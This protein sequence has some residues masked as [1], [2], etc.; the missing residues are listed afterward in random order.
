MKHIE[1]IMMSIYYQV[2]FKFYIIK[3][4][5]IYVIYNN[6]TH[7]ATVKERMRILNQTS[8]NVAKLSAI[9]K[10][11]DMGII[12]EPIDTS[13]TYEKLQEKLYTDQDLRKKVYNLFNNDTQT[14]EDFLE[15]FEQNNKSYDN[16]NLV[17]NQ[18][19]QQF[20]GF[21]ASPVVVFDVMNKLSKNVKQTG[22]P[23]SA[24]LYD[25][26]RE[27]QVFLEEQFKQNN[28][29]KEQGDDMVDKLNAINELLIRNVNL[30]KDETSSFIN[31]SE[32]LVETFE[33]VKI[34]M[35]SQIDE[36]N[37]LATLINELSKL[38][39]DTFEVL[40]KETIT[41]KEISIKK[42]IEEINNIKDEIITVETEIN[43]KSD[44]RGLS[45]KNEKL[46]RLE[47]DLDEKEKKYNKLINDLNEYEPKYNN[48]INDTSNLKE[49]D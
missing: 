46:N 29:S 30:K 8:Q 33:N 7:E 43:N 40:L 5:Y 42:Y 32:K 9:M 37:K 31:A 21:L 13:T 16:F 24:G 49:K 26:L 10:N 18:L 15:L 14:A 4:F 45:K 17:Y 12:P 48:L 47:N 3:I 27:A 2:I 6:M 36:V 34:T 25:E 38:T 19:L 44:N 35:N 41:N 1:K 20:K 11:Y 28:I 39:K 23:T 22:V